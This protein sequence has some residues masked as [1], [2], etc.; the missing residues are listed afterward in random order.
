MKV[1]IVILN[2]NGKKLLEKF[3][4]SV[5][6]HNND[7][8]EIIVADNASSDASIDF[9]TSNYKGIV[10][11]IRND[12][13]FGFA[14]GYN[15][16][17]SQINAEYFV[18]LNSDIEVS[19]GWIDGIIALMD[20]DKSIAACQPKILAYHNKEAF[21]YAGAGGGFIDKWGYP[22]C[23]G[24]LFQTIEK[25]TL[26]YNQ[27]EEIFWASGACLFVR[28]AAYK[29]AGGLDGDFFA[30]ME[31]IDLCWRLKNMGYKIMYNP[32]SV[33]YHVGGGTLDKMSPRK[34]FLNFRNNLS[35]IYKNTPE[36]KLKSVLFTRA[37]LDFV[38][39]IS[40]IFSGGF[41]HFWAVI[42]A[43]ATF[44]ANIS[45]ERKKRAALKQNNVSCIYQRS[46]VSEYYIKKKRYFS[47]L[48]KKDFS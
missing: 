21:E 45:K 4:P 35:L 27:T 13:N 29:E 9:I 39:A 5:I 41:S 24:R 16:A 31:E 40:F 47:M 17:L 14:E 38:A 1:A 8:A 26:Q 34:T 44:Y 12:K 19:S 15:K 33:V 2:W 22:F 42:R 20:S 30:H 28:A 36:K 3:L 25:D 7:Y 37:V 32:T 43:Y 6:A 23:K 11:I 18:L 46:I 10:R 48:N